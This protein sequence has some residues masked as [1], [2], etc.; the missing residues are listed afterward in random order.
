MYYLP[1]AWCIIMIKYVPL[2][3]LQTAVDK[4]VSVQSLWLLVVSNRRTGR[5][6]GEP[7]SPTKLFG[8]KLR[9]YKRLRLWY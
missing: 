1:A 3:K 7:V 4:T 6:S 2:V 9:S 8:T 5:I